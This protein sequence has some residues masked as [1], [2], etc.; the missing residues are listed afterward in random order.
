[1]LAHLYSA[2][3]GCP[4]RP[5]A[6]AASA[7]HVVVIQA[8]TATACKFGDGCGDAGSCCAVRNAHA[9][10]RVR[11]R[12]CTCSAMQRS[13]SVGTTKTLIWEPAAWI[14]AVLPPVAAL[15]L[16]L[17]TM[18]PN[19]CPFMPARVKHI[20]AV[21]A[22]QPE[23]VC[24]GVRCAM[25]ESDVNLT[26]RDQVQDDWPTATP[27]H[28]QALE[29]QPS[30]QSAVFA[31]ACAQHRPSL[32]EL[33]AAHVV[34]VEPLLT[35]GSAVVWCVSSQECLQRTDDAHLQCRYAMHR[36]AHIPAENT[37]ASVVP[38]SSS[39]YAPRYLRTL[40]TYTCNSTSAHGVTDTH[41]SFISAVLLPA[42]MCPC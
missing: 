20:C 11:L 39:R 14:M 38:W 35:S 41:W 2:S 7:A 8:P 40:W 6:S 36:S 18:M 17:S 15:F 1:M 31:N 16:A 29:R 13:S 22:W 5:P 25:H 12:T 42:C 9:I 3:A 32:L 21:A 27:L 19:A 26:S 10:G 37:M 28:L 24:C 30:D 4:P 33:T 34:A 23:T